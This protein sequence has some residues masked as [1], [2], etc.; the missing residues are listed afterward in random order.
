MIR[1]PWRLAGLAL[2]GLVI[3][4]L[5]CAGSTVSVGVGYGYPYPYGPYGGGAV[6]G[7]TI[8]VGYGWN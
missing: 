1:H 8:P 4:V 7:T 6:I 3:L 2:V 5:A